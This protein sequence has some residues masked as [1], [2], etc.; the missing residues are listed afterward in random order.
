MSTHAL[1]T[2]SLHPHHPLLCLASCFIGIHI[3][4]S[5]TDPTTHLKTT[6]LSR[7]GFSD[8][9]LAGGGLLYTWQWTKW[10]QNAHN[11]HLFVASTCRPAS[12]GLHFNRLWFCYLWNGIQLM[13]MLLHLQMRCSCVERSHVTLV[14]KHVILYSHSAVARVSWST[15]I[16]IDE[17]PIKVTVVLHRFLIILQVICLLCP[18]RPIVLC[19]QFLCVVQLILH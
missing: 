4:P 11:S 9:L 12:V 1:Q 6:G 16:L 8:V 5:I 19:E 2:F 3:D 14:T 13:V 18:I 17:I 7:S 15:Y 10:N